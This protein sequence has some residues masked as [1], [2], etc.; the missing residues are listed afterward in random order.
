MP[1]VSVKI[2][3][4]SRLKRSN[5]FDYNFRFLVVGE[6]GQVHI[7]DAVSAAAA[8]LYVRSKLFRP[9]PGCVDDDGDCYSVAIRI[10]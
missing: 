9:G 5:P 3:A 4:A 7:S 8:T 1:S 10:S 2:I 6:D